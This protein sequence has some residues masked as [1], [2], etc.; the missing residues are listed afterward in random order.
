MGHFQ[1]NPDEEEQK[2]QD[3]INLANKKEV[4][5][6]EAEDAMDLS[7]MRQLDLGEATNYKTKLCQKRWEI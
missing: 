7:E 4:P 1:T 6:T 2:R 3:V 5:L